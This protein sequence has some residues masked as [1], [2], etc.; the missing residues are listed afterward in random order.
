MVKL[1]TLGRIVDCLKWVSGDFLMKGI[2]SF[3]GHSV[4]L[5]QSG[6]LV[7]GIETIDLDIGILEFGLCSF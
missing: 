3:W 2:T 6:S 7:I 4:Q 5:R 1:Q